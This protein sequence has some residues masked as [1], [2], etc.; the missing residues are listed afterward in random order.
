MSL[1]S[2]PVEDLVAD[3]LRQHAP[4]VGLRPRDVD[5]VVQEDVGALAPDH[6]RERVEVVVVDH[7]D[8]LLVALDL[9]EH[10]AR[11][12]LVDGVVAVLEGLDLLAADVGRVALVPQVVLDEP[13]HRVGDDVVEARRRP[14]GRTRRSARGTRRRAAPRPRTA[15]SPCS[16]ETSTSRSVIAE[17]IQIASR[18]E[19]RPVS[20]VTRPPVPRLTEPSSWN[21]TGPRLETRTS[22]RSRSG[23]H[24]TSWKIF[25]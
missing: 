18:C 6:A 17:A 7:H 19:A 21:V 24:N 2:S 15:R 22:G 20:A 14:R 9:L 1:A 4:G 13:Q 11:E 25:R 8:G 12:V 23:I 5:E 10:G 3:V 16:R